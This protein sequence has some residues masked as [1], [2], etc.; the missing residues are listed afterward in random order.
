M[1]QSNRIWKT[2][3]RKPM[4]V[5]GMGMLSMIIFLALFA[6]LASSFSFLDFE[7]WH[8]SNHII[9]GTYPGCAPVARG[10]RSHQPLPIL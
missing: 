6:H 9:S 4:A 3:R 1:N 10:G 2:F 8:E 7:Q 5:V